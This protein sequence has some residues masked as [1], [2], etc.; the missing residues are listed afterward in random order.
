MEGYIG[1]GI[2][3]QFFWIYI[4]N[5]K[6]IAKFYVAI[7]KNCSY[8]D[9][10]KFVIFSWILTCILSLPSITDFCEFTELHFIHMTLQYIKCWLKWNNSFKKLNALNLDGL[11][12]I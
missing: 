5:W 2:D 8:K 4:V 9:E 12:V 1:L 6:N 11:T 3:S 10:S 7:I